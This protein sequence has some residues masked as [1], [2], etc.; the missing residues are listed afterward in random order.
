VLNLCPNGLY[1]RAATPG[2]TPPGAVSA[3]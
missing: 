2:W 3:T 1:I